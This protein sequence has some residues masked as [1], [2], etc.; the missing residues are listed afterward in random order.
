MT[1]TGRTDLAEEPAVPA[2]A[3][4]ALTI[5]QRMDREHLLACAHEAG[6]AVLMAVY[7]LPITEAVAKAV[8]PVFGA[9]RA[10]GYVTEDCGP[11]E[12]MIPA[13]V[14]DEHIVTYL[15]GAEAQA[16]WMHLAEEW[17]LAAARCEAI[18]SH[19]GHDYQVA[20]RYARSSDHSFG[21]L[22]ARTAALVARHWGAIT[23]VAAELHHRKRLTGPQILHLIGR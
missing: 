10:Y 7:N 17:D 9:P 20:R 13:E 22:Q 21:Q 5:K 4:P 14:I 6:H 23:R 8:H 16:R 1:T 3:T 18:S 2:P 19:A 11:G 15:A 12:D